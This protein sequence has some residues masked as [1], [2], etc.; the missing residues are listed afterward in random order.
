MI[1]YNFWR[2]ITLFYVMTGKTQWNFDIRK[3]IL[4]FPW[5]RHYKSLYV[6]PWFVIYIF[7]AYF[8]LKLSMLIILYKSLFVT[9]E[10]RKMKLH[11]LFQKLYYRNPSLQRQ[12]KSRISSHHC[13]W[14]SQGSHDHCSHPCQILDQLHVKLCLK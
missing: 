11:I 4:K 8:L 12:G 2:P 14:P 7:K 1:V 13:K 3:I 10:S 5:I 6:L 9:N